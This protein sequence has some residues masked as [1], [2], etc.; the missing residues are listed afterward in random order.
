M[1][2]KNASES[3]GLF[4]FPVHFSIELILLQLDY[5]NLLPIQL[6]MENTEEISEKPKSGNFYSVMVKLGVVCESCN[7]SIPINGFV[8]EVECPKCLKLTKLKGKL[9]W[10]QLLNYH[11]PSVDVFTATTKHK[12]G[13]GDFGAWQPVKLKTWRKW[14]TC[15]NCGAKI[16]EKLFEQVISGKRDFSCK[17]CSATI[18]F[19]PVPE[20]IKKVFPQVLFSLDPLPPDFHKLTFKKK[21]EEI[22]PVAMQCMTCGGS[23]KIDGKLRMIP[24][25]FCTSNNYLPD[26]VWLALHP[27]QEMKEW[28]IVFKK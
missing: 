13:E 14:P 27:Q 23:L 2:L 20:Q 16:D 7:N 8:H 9:R 28:F 3:G 22:N 25:E 18:P 12:L 5:R 6:K 10:Q 1:G 24:C 4:K 17:M 11:N 26:E 21:R 15:R 19:K